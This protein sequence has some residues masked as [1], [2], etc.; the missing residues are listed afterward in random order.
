MVP[1]SIVKLTVMYVHAVRWSKWIGSLVVINH[2]MVKEHILSL[3]GSLIP[4]VRFGVVPT[5][6]GVDGIVLNYG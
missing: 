4:I 2:L 6:N 5:H 1:C 3:M